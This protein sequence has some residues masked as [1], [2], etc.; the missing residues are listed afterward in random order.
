M[1]Q[2]MAFSGLLLCYGP[3]LLVVGGFI[4]FAFLTDRHATRQYLR[5]LDPR[6]EAER[7]DEGPLPVNKSMRSR[8]ASG[9]PVVLQP[10]AEAAVAVPEMEA[11]AMPDDLKKVEGI[12]LKIEMVLKEAGVTT[13][14][15]MATMSGEEIRKI[16]D[17]AEMAAIH[18]PAS[19]DKQ[20]ALVAE[21]K[22]EELRKM[23]DEL[24]GGQA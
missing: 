21:G 10:A 22:W 24:Q 20:A 16:L 4:A 15:K 13:F 5:R 12:G 2:Q 23:Q 1:F 17:D 3:L 18:K 6:P 8:T 7:V 11:Q 9:V 14:A 19:W